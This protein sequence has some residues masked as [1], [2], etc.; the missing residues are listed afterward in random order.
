ML[1]RLALLATVLTSARPAYAQAN[2][3]YDAVVKG[4]KCTQQRSGQLDCEY[5][6]GRSLRLEIAGV[7]QS[8]AA[9]TFYKVDFDGDF[10]AT[11][12]VLHGCV[13]VKPAHHPPGQF[14]QFAFISPKDG[15]VYLDWET[16][17]EA[18]SK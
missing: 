8:D 5:R 11:V 1:L 7:G 4:L 15:K 2:P 3:T 10:Y 14:S 6:V 13:V 12:G 9:I 18:G 17:S 16:C